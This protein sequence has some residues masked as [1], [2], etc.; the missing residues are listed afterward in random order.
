[1]LVAFEHAGYH[2]DVPFP[3]WLAKI[4]ATAS[5]STCS[6]GPATGSSMS[7][8]AGS[9]TRWRAEVL[10]RQVRLCP[11]E[12]LLW[13]KA[14]VQERER[15]DGADVLHLLHACARTL[16]W[17]RVLVRFRSLG[18]SSSAIWSRSSSSIPIAAT[19]YRPRSWRTGRAGSHVSTEARNRVCYGTMMSREQYLHDVNVL[20]YVDARLVPRGTMT[21]EELAI[22]T[23][24]IGK[25]A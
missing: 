23:D 25:Q 22:W 24:A 1:M 19:T 6:S 14:F 13:S 21:P 16:D 8:T 5:I 10:D 20:G 17:D 3:H 15:F 11:P 9:R 18:P 4:P 7:T 12:E 2:A